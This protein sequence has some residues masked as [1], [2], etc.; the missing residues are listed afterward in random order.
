M[1]ENLIVCLVSNKRRDDVPDD[2]VYRVVK[3]YMALKL[4]F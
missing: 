3:S 2:E 1:H 4:P